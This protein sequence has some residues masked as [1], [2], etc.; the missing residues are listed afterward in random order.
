MRATSLVVRRHPRIS[1]LALLVVAA[2]AAVILAVGVSG[3]AAQSG[4][5]KTADAVGGGTSGSL[6]LHEGTA[7][8]LALSGDEHSIVMNFMGNL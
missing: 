3:S 5:Q 7:L 8:T 1:V 2:L 4:Q 6:N